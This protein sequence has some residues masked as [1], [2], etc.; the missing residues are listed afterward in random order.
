MRRNL[1]L[2]FKGGRDYIHG[3]DM[4]NSVM[5]ELM[6]IR[7]VSDIS[8]LVFIINRMTARNL[9]LVV[10]EEEPTEG[11]PV[12]S[13]TF[14]TRGAKQRAVLV[15]RVEEPRGR[16]EYDEDALCTHC[17]I[18]VNNR[19][20]VMERNSTFSPIETMVAMTK[21]LH[22]AVFPGNSGQWLFGRL[23]APSWPPGCLSEGFTISLGQTLGTRLTKS[24][25]SL[26]AETLAW[27]YF[28]MKEQH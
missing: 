10:H 14:E 20:I 26:G 17:R 5:R 25:A 9:D 2:H 21:A 13:L 22:L 11:L 3:T 28:A 15:E 1:D 8:N 27:I 18:D 7:A 16:D 4:V 6:Q 12:A 23:E 24:R 19:I